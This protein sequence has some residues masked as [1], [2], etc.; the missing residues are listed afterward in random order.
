VFDL[1]GLNGACVFQVMTAALSSLDLGQEAA[2]AP[3]VAQ[4]V[5]DAP[6]EVATASDEVVASM[7]RVGFIDCF[8]DIGWT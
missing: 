2:A 1:P 7:V 6:Q 8:C 3:A 5:Q 4:D